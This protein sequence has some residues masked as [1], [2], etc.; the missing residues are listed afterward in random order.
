MTAIGSINAGVYLITCG[1]TKSAY[2]G[3]SG[4][5]TRRKRNH[6][7]PNQPHDNPQLCQ[8]MVQYGI[9]SFVFTV[10]EYLQDKQDRLAAEKKW[11]DCYSAQGYV[12]YNL[13]AG[14]GK[15]FF[16]SNLARQNMA[17]AQQGKQ[18]TPQTKLKISQ[19]LT[20]KPRKPSAVRKTAKAHRGKTVS[21]ETRQKMSEAHKG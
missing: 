10:L 21:A 9:A 12:M 18:H 15:K 5:L 11:F 19:A 20:G 1:Q 7:N 17:T 3:E 14:G 2:I 16:L 6:L 13:K 4:N 8:D